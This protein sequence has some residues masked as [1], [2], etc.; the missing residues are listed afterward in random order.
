MGIMKSNKDYFSDPKSN[1]NLARIWHREKNDKKQSRFLAHLKLE[2]GRPASHRLRFE[3]PGEG[4]IKILPGTQIW[5]VSQNVTNSKY[6]KKIWSGRWVFVS[7]SLH[8]SCTYVS[9]I[10]RLCEPV[11]NASQFHCLLCRTT[12]TVRHCTC[13]QSTCFLSLLVQ[14]KWWV[15]SIQYK[16]LRAQILSLKGYILSATL[17]V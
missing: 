10:N 14:G 8:Q 1:T 12:Q 5:H 16:W 17:Y 9:N 11:W 3:A 6:F 2:N 13:L 15:V 4:N 7:L